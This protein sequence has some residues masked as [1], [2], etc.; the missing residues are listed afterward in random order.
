[1]S[2]IDKSPASQSQSQQ[3]NTWVSQDKSK[4]YYGQT[5]TNIGGKI[6][7]LQVN[8]YNNASLANNLINSGY[9]TSNQNSFSNSS[10]INNQLNFNPNISKNQLNFNTKQVN[11]F[12]LFR[13][14]KNTPNNILNPSKILGIN[15]NKKSINY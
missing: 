5:V 8:Q 7:P 1:M 14:N 10:K 15:I 13:Q 4:P 11:D 6:A 9:T 12:N 3:S 2:I